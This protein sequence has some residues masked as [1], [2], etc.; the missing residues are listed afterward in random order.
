MTTL[1][2]NHRKDNGKKNDGYIVRLAVFLVF[3]IILLVVLG[4]SISNTKPS[5]GYVPASNTSDY[6]RNGTGAAIP[7][8]A[9]LLTP[10]GG[11]YETVHHTYYSL[12]YSEEHEQAAWVAYTLTDQSLYV[13]NVNRA[14]KFK[15]DP[16]VST[17]S[18]TH[19]DY[20]HSGYTRGHMAPAGDMA[21]NRQAMEETFYM[22]NMSPQIKQLNNG[23]WKE[24]EE[25]VRDWAID[26][27]E[28]VIVTGP[29]LTNIK[30]KIGKKNKISVPG[31]FYKVIL[32]VD[33]SNRD[34]IAFV[35]PHRV[36]DERLQDFAVTIDS[37]EEITGLDFFINRTDI[38]DIDNLE[39][40][41]N[42]SSWQFD[43]K[44]YK[45]RINKWNHEK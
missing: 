1:R 40:S 43:E 38:P 29:I 20:S 13:P 31:A 24:L 18:A 4:Y 7:Q 12:G 45:D 2:N 36:C 33:G 26:K 25:S 3:C 34:G 14:K 17:Y 8:T 21:F 15:Y 5:K 11:N 19:S 32:D 28:L 16:Q 23:I 41:I 35:I 10:G 39:N 44:R 27:K 42:I 22:S 9:K 30:K 37:V 6:H